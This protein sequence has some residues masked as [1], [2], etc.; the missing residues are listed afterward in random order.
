[1]L[2]KTT[3]ALFGGFLCTQL[4][5]CVNKL[6]SELVETSREEED[7]LVRVSHAGERDSMPT[8][9][10]NGK[11]VS[12]IVYGTLRLHTMDDPNALLDLVYASGCNAFDVAA[13]YGGGKCEEVLGKWVRSRK[14]NREDVFILTKGGVGPQSD[15]WAAD[16]DTDRLRREVQESLNRLGFEYVDLYMLH[17]DDVK[18]PISEI[19]DL[20]NEFI[21]NG[22][23]KSWGVSNWSTTRIQMAIDYAKQTGQAQP[24][25]DSPQFSLAQPTRAVWPGT[26][27]MSPERLQFYTEDRNVNV[28]CW[29]VLA[30]GYMAGKW[31]FDKICEEKV[32]LTKEEILQQLATDPDQWR[33]TNLENAYLTKQN[34]GRRE[35]AQVLADQKGVELCEIAIA[36]ILAKHPRTFALAGTTSITNW[37]KNV[38]AAQISLSPLEVRFLEGGESTSPVA[39]KSLL[40]IDNL[41]VLL[42]LLC[43]FTG[44]LYTDS[45]HADQLIE[46]LGLYMAFTAALLYNFGQNS[47][48][49]IAYMTLIVFIGYVSISQWQSFQ[50]GAK[51]F[52]VASLFLA[53]YSFIEHFTTT[54]QHEEK[55][56]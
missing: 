16:L 18:K 48:K 40:T 56:V 1:M 31:G 35:R 17:R 15:L 23:A 14:V 3:V 20:M 32:P 28:F 19:V 22:Y 53:E 2:G 54:Q 34:Y 55:L 11:Q 37:N 6:F 52:I 47:S 10:M 30:K 38:K 5:V 25:C 51:I 39:A 44:Q 12:R 9:M 27:Y 33:T 42:M 45:P 7:L 50:F 49:L 29:E 8:R 36:Y 41:W 26:S 4:K 46:W 21:T 13:I 43:V 24:I